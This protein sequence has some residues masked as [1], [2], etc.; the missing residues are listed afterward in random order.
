MNSLIGREICRGCSG[1]KL[2]EVIDFGS[3]PLANELTLTKENA[4]EYPLVFSV[5]LDCSLGQVPNIVRP[6]RIFQDYRYT[7]S[8]SATFA[9]HAESFVNATIVAERIKPGDFIL[10]IASNDG[11]LL[12]HFLGKGFQL[13]GVEPAV[14]IAKI[15][16]E[17]GVPTLSDFFDSQVAMK[18]L[19]LYGYPKL[20]IAN[21]V[22]A[23]VPDLQNFIK[24]LRILSNKDTLISIENPSINNL[25]HKLQFDT[26]YHEHFSYLSATSVDV[27]FRQND[28]YLY[29]VETLQIHGG[30]NRY[31]IGSNQGKTGPTVEAK[32]QSELDIRSTQKW[33]DFS[34][35]VHTSLSKFN[36]WLDELSQLGESV[37]G[38]GAA[39]K[40]STFLNM[41]KIKEGSIKAI[42]DS[43]AEKIG[44]F[45][46]NMQIPIFHT[47]EVQR[48][49][50]DHLIVFPWN[51]TNELIW[52]Y[53]TFSSQATRFWRVTPTISEIDLMN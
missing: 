35:K 26:I 39:A 20:I 16:S 7:S 45:M 12:K 24:G 29:E 47:S 23:H 15:A 50:I 25:L 32:V 31:L 9:D 28:L 41:A 51:I 8:T 14:N 40:A 3:L 36:E 4:N 52:D 22:L 1:K 18:I 38:I 13:L 34:S 42:F 37:Y 11:Y 17:I 43:S 21:N 44:R 19:Q 53:R 48:F 6:N 46:P 10:E 33:T 27:M 5:C 30:T 2:N 49:D